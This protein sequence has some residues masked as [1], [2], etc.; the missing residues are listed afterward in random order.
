MIS[1]ALVRLGGSKN[2]ASWKVGPREKDPTAD[3][4]TKAF[5]FLRR[6]RTTVDG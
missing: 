3:D 1:G 6:G 5:S 4:G 2:A